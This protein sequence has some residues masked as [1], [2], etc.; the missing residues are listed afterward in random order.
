[1]TDRSP[2]LERSLVD[3]GAHLRFPATPDLAAMV[4]PRLSSR[5]GRVWRLPRRALAAMAVF[6]VLI[7]AGLAV[8]PA[9]RTALAELLGVPGIR[10]T[11][12]QSPAAAEPLGEDLQLGEQA[13]LAEASR[14]VGFSVSVPALLGDPDEVYV[15]GEPPVVWLVYAA[16]PALPA[17]GESTIGLL[18]AQF[19]VGPEELLIE[20][21]IS[22][23]VTIEPVSVGGRPGFWIEGQH[24]VLIYDTGQGVREESPRLA[25]NTLIWERDGRSLR[26]EAD[27]DQEQAVRIAESME[28][29]S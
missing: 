15:G 6:L 25:G 8:S 23:G 26:L 10:V 28:D 18:V 20:K 2:E 7:V 1:M 22:P 29:T 27:L 13:S 3:L 14:R 21:T 16:G 19:E 24:P 5:P 17:V 9:A 4:A 11:I 12:D